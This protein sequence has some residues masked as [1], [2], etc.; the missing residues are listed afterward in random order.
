MNNTLYLVSF[1][2]DH[3]EPQF[4]GA[5]EGEVQGACPETAKNASLYEKQM[6]TGSRIVR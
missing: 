6:Q 1:H 2:N 4:D 5:Q 3:H